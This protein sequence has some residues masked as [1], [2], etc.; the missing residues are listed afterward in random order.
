MRRRLVFAIV[1]SVA[2]ALLVAGLSSLLLVRRAARD[3]T[4]VE[5]VREVRALAQA[6]EETQRTRV[7]QVVQRVLKLEGLATVRFGPRGRTVDPPPSGLT[8]ADL[9]PDALIQG[10]TV[11]GTRGN[12]VYAAAPV[13][14]PSGGAAAVVITRRLPGANKGIAYFLLAAGFALFVALA[15]AEWLARQILKPLSE[16]E[17]ATGRIAAGDLTVHVPEPDASYPELASLARSINM[18]AESLSRSRGLER[19]FLLSV[20]HDLRTPLTSIRGFAEA[21]A[22]GAA[23]DHERAADVIAAEAR[24]LERLVKDLLDLAKLEARRFT[25]DVH[26]TDVAAIAADTAEGFRPATRAESVTLT[27]DVP[28]DELLA[29]ADPERLAQVI[30]NLTENALKYAAS[31]I[32]VS[33]QATGPAVVLTVTDDGPGIPADELPRVFER[34]YTTARQPARSGVGSGLGLAIVSE[35][36]TAMGGTVRAEAGPSGGT[37]MVVSLRSWSSSAWPSSSTSSTSS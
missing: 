13:A 5:L 12:L 4:R 1:G 25:L 35:L 28:D 24:R 36:V 32:V 27:I 14:T 19:Q 23:E 18:M 15:V 33:A 8:V 31:S 26:R 2:G 29:A 20:S 22:D 11:S 9:R 6:A 21:I 30:A 7:V 17:A 10:S 34:L 16:A 3:D 37:R